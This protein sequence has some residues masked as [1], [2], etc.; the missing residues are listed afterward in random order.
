MIPFFSSIFYFS[1]FFHIATASR[2]N[3]LVIVADDLGY[4]DVSWHNPDIISPNLA[5]HNFILDFADVQYAVIRSSSDKKSQICL[6]TITLAG[7]QK[8]DWC[9][10][11]HMCSQSVPQLGGQGIFLK[12]WNIYVSVDIFG[13]VVPL[14]FNLRNVL[15]F[16]RHPLDEVCVDERIVPNPH[17]TPAQRSLA[18]GASRIENIAHSSAKATQLKVFLHWRHCQAAPRGRICNSHGGQVAPGLL[19]PRDAAHKQVGQ[20]KLRRKWKVARLPKI[21]GT[22][23]VLQLNYFRGFDTFYGYYTGSEHYFNHTRWSSCQSKI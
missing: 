2:P 1:A 17:G 22:V 21:F 3:I 18:G 8:K 11:N 9:W 12:T 13:L 14:F 5:R 19:L 6:T 16:W 15:L 20:N 10:N 23:K 4:N 7:L